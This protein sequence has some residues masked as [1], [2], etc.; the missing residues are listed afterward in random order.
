MSA[1]AARAAF[2]FQ[3]IAT[4]TIAAVNF[5]FMIFKRLSAPRAE[6]NPPI[7]CPFKS[8][9]PGHCLIFA[10]MRKPGAKKDSSYPS[11][12]FYQRK[13]NAKDLAQDFVVKRLVALLW[14][15][16]IVTDA[17]FNRFHGMRVLFCPRHL[18]QLY[19]PAIAGRFL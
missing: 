9:A 5:D 6:V 13:G 10:R 16:S 19:E 1:S 3:S 14:N 7:T 11:Y 18:R 17:D 15:G 12:Q 4:K 2:E 8:G